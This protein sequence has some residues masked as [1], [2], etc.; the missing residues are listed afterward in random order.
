MKLA[1]GGSFILSIL[2]RRRT[3][4]HI[5]TSKTAIVSLRVSVSE[6]IFHQRGDNLIRAQHKLGNM[7]PNLNEFLS[8]LKFPHIVSIIWHGNKMYHFQEIH[9]V[10]SPIRISLTPYF[11]LVINCIE[12]IE[13]IKERE[14]SA[15]Y[16]AK[17]MSDRMMK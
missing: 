8:D 7:R 13:S 10:L 9:F 12:G 6:Q 14:F 1:G 11:P 5:K 17:Q 16:K 4:H 2:H 15:K 3:F